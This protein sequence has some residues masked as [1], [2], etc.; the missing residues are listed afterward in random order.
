MYQ[1]EHMDFVSLVTSA[2]EWVHVVINVFTVLW[3]VCTALAASLRAM[4]EEKYAALEK[5]WPAFGH[6]ARSA[7]K[8]GTDVLPF[9]VELGKGVM[10]IF[11]RRG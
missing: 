3:L 1:G 6:F 9:V 8:F 11:I 4:P 10:S 2:P 5:A 7:R